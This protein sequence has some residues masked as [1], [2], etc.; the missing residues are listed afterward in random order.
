[1]IN[2]AYLIILGIISFFSSHLWVFILSSSSGN[3]PEWATVDV[4]SG[5]LRTRLCVKHLYNNPSHCVHLGSVI[6]TPC[7]F[8]HGA[9]R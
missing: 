4:V 8:E 2:I 5:S 3:S 6:L 9:G 1:M 7:E